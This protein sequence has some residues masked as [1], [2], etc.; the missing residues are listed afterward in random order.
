MLFFFKKKRPPLEKKEPPE[1]GFAP[2]VIGEK[3]RGYLI[4]ESLGKVEGQKKDDVGE[5]EKAKP[6][7]L[8]E[9][10]L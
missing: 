9:E 3:G 7:S 5:V 2:E 10:H 1:N 8:K 6:E 4:G